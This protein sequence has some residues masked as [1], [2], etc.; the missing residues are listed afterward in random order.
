MFEVT[1]ARFHRPR[2]YA[3][4]SA[5]D[6]QRRRRYSAADR[7]TRQSD[8]TSDRAHRRV[9]EKKVKIILRRDISK[10]LSCK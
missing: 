1:S 2:S 5:S 3:D 9:R 8:I 4:V 7:T 6:G 10:D